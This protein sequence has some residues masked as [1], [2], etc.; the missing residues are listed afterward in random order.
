[1]TEDKYRL[2]H[3]EPK[4]MM[5]YHMICKAYII[6][7]FEKVNKCEMTFN[8]IVSACGLDKATVGICVDEMLISGQLKRLM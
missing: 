6:D 1:M 8:E 7:S 3:K 2:P 4:K 5:G